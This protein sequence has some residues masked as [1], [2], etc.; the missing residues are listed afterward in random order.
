MNHMDLEN[1][2]LAW[3][4][5]HPKRNR[6][7]E[8]IIEGLGIDD[9]MVS[10]RRAGLE[11]LFRQGIGVRPRTNAH[12][13]RGGAGFFEDRG[14]FV[15]VFELLAIVEVIGI[16]LLGRLDLEGRSEKLEGILGHGFAVGF[17]LDLEIAFDFDRRILF[18]IGVDEETPRAFRGHEGFRQE[19]LD[20]I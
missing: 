12:V 20:R 14:Q 1:Q 8:D 5:S 18:Q 16:L 19:Q 6:R 9:L 2:I 11:V 10:L 17:L 3:L 7:M 4:E 13:G 15:I